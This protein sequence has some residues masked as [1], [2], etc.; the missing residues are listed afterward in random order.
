MNQKQSESIDVADLGIDEAVAVVERA[1]E[2]LEDD[3]VSLG[4]AK[5]L[6]DNAL[7]VLDHIEAELD[8]EEGEVTRTDE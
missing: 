6:R 2:Q 4:E 3:Q 7:E 5:Q 8:V 1:I